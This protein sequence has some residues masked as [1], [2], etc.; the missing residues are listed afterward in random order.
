MQWIGQS[1]LLNIKNIQLRKGRGAILFKK[2]TYFLVLMISSLVLIAFIVAYCIP[3][4]DIQ[5]ALDHNQEDASKILKTFRE[6]FSIIFSFM[7]LLFTALNMILTHTKTDQ[8]FFAIKHSS[9]T[10]ENEL[11][12]TLEMFNESKRPLTIFNVGVDGLNTIDSIATKIDPNQAYM[13]ICRFQIPALRSNTICNS[14]FLPLRI[15]YSW[16][17]DR[18]T[19]KR[20]QLFRNNFHQKT[21]RSELASKIATTGR[22]KA[23][24]LWNCCRS[25]KSQI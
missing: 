23:A 11:K 13:M 9:L 19:S 18:K 1:D 7:A 12:I 21:I 6:Y 10:S 20:W 4:I 24:N 8:L 2:T 15:N 22:L 3:H 5:I 25:F 14:S 17:G 16:V